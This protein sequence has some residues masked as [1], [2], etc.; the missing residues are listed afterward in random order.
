MKSTFLFSLLC[1]ECICVTNIYAQVKQTEDLPVSVRNEL[2]SAASEGNNTEDN[3]EFQEQLN[4]YIKHPLNINTCSP[5]EIESFPLLTSIQT[6]AILEHRNKFGAF[7]SLEE[8]QVINELSPEAIRNLLPFVSTGNT[9]SGIKASFRNLITK[10][11]Q[12]FTL[13]YQKSVTAEPDPENNESNYTGAPYKLFSRYKYKF[14]DRFRFSLTGEKD[15][16]ESLFKPPAKYGFDYLSGYFE[17]QKKGLIRKII[18]GDYSY[19]F[20]QGLVIWSGFG[21]GKSSETVLLKKN[22]RGMIPY[23]STDE[24]NFMRGLAV[25]STYKKISVDLFLSKHK[26]DGNSLPTDTGN[27]I[28]ALQNTGYHRNATELEDK[29]SQS[30]QIIGAALNY[31]TE[32]LSLGSLCYT[33]EFSL[34]FQQSDEA[35]NLFEFHNNKNTN[36]GF[37]YNYIYRNMNM[38]GEFGISASGGKALLQGIMAQLHPNFSTSI[39]LRKYDEN[40]QALKAHAFSENSLTSNE[41]GW[42]V[43]INWKVVRGITLVSYADYFQ[44]PWLRYQVD[45]PSTGKEY[46][47]QVSWKPKKTIEMYV[48]YRNQSKEENEGETSERLHNL[49]PRV[50]KNF[51]WSIRMDLDECWEWSSRFEWV[52]SIK[53]NE[54]TGTGFAAYQEIFYH[55]LKSFISGSLRY[56][57]FNCPDYDSRIFAYEN[58]VLYSYS[59][60]AAYGSGSRYYLNLRFR[61]CRGLNVWAKYSSTILLKAPLSQDPI[62]LQKSS[63]DY[64]LQVIYQF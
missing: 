45:A 26:I 55:P 57:V 11:E 40:Y 32:N 36:A 42:Y 30:E 21:F 2:E 48:R 43:G 58:D 38:F 10:A 51:R 53:K 33:T 24:N 12:S 35:R 52:R 4:E 18:L 60:P 8:L 1:I 31:T 29:H 61:I 50:Q 6:L 20:G 47:V 23:S 7:R 9:V 63:G 34:H 16:G 46:L 3:I 37:H 25:R 59:I 49:I 22:A 39:L 64:K 5:E 44:F 15:A 41:A 17:I 28:S 54:S 19:Q 62:A 14:G 27:F 13:R 56:A